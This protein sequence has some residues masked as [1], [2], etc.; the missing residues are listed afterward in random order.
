MKSVA[1]FF[2]C[3]ALTAG[4]VGFSAAAALAAKGEDFPAQR[5][6]ARVARKEG[7]TLMVTVPAFARARQC[8]RKDRNP[9]TTAKR[10]GG[11]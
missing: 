11:R 2:A 1:S 4:L 3:V 8:I 6:L 7:G 9:M 10:P 5:V